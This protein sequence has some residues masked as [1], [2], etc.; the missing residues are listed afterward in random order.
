M[1]N[2]HETFSFTCN[3][4]Q[5]FY[6]T[7]LPLNA[8]DP[9]YPRNQLFNFD[10]LYLTINPPLYIAGFQQMYCQSREQFFGI[11]PQVQSIATTGF[12]GNGV[13]TTFTG[14]V[15][16]S[17]AI[18]APNQFVNNT[19]LQNQVLF[20]SLDTNLNGL[21]MVDMPIADPVTGN[22]TVIGNL[23]PSARKPTTPPLVVNLQNTINYATGRYTVT[24][25]DANF[26]NTAPGPNQPINSQTVNVQLARPQAM[27]FYDNG[28]TLRPVPDQ[29]YTIQFEVYKRPI[30][31]DKTKFTIPALEEY[32]QYIAFSTSKKIFEDRMDMDSVQLIMP[33]LKDQERLVLRRTL[34]QNSTQRVAT[35]YT[36]NVNGANIL[37]WGF[38]GGQF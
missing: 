30:P 15:N 4:Y 13:T 8:V 1:W 5:D 23:Y 38:G 20:S 7:N 21:A 28:F 37:G 19:I 11:Y 14:W 36:E 25:Q 27:L 33:A 10:N 9:Q 31:L 3:P 24:F 17:Q 12:F 34:K 29:P 22:P 2:F 16:T 32:W 18:I 26:T 6:P 35:I